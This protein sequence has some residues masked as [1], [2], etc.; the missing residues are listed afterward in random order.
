MRDISPY[1]KTRDKV[2][3]YFLTRVQNVILFSHDKYILF[4]AVVEV[5]LR[6]I[7]VLINVYR[8][9]RY[10]RMSSVFNL[11]RCFIL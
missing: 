1:D 6:E 7:K 5:F 4:Q 3:S 9:Q 2:M 8:F 11:P 10:P